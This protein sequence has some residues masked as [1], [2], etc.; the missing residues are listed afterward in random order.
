VWPEY[1]LTYE[2]QRVFTTSIVRGNQAAQDLSRRSES[3]LLSGAT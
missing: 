1:L 2:I 3:G